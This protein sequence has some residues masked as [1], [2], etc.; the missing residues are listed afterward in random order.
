M[1]EVFAASDTQSRKEQRWQQ[2][3]DAMREKIEAFKLLRAQLR[4]HLAESEVSIIVMTL[5]NIE[6]RRGAKAR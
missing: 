6:A 5:T 4:D 3:R 1:Y 2:T